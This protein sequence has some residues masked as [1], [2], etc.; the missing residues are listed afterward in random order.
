MASTPTEGPAD[1]QI[2]GGLRFKAMQEAPDFTLKD[3]DG[4][5][6]S[7]S[8][9]HGTNVLLQFYNYVSQRHEKAMHEMV[10][11]GLHD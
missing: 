6:L 2:E 11:S 10:E 7:L 4:Q 3:Y 1:V 9:F 5:D 8:Q